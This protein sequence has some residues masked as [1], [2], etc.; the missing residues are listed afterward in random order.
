MPNS[1]RTWLIFSILTFPYSHL[2]GIYFP[3]MSVKISIISLG[4]MASLLLLLNPNKM[5]NPFWILPQLCLCIFLCNS[6]TWISTN[7]CIQR[8]EIHLPFASPSSGFLRRMQDCPNYK[9]GFHSFVYQGS[10][11]H[12]NL[13]HNGFSWTQVSFFI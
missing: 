3:T 1:C 12:G 11:F 8:S 6:N 9:Q 10:L 4:H 2:N 13:Q 5:L 7:P